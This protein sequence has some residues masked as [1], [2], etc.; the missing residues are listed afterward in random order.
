MHVIWARGQEPGNY[1][2]APPSGLEK[3]SASVKEFYKPDELKYHGHK[4]QRGF[5]QI[6]FFDEIKPAANNDSTDSPH[7]LDN[8]CEGFWKHP[9]TCEPS[10]FNCEYHVSWQTIGRGDEMRFQIQT[11]NTK[12]WT[13]IGFSED[14]KMSQTDAIIGWVDQNGRPFLMDT[15]INGFS[16]PKLDDQQNIYNISGR[17]Q[18]GATTLEFTRKRQTDDKSDLSF[19]DDHCLRLMFPVAGGRFNAVNKKMSKH[20]QTPIVTEARICIKS[21]GRDLIDNTIAPERKLPSQLAY[22]VSVKL[23]NLAESFE[24]PSK[25]TPEFDSLASQLSNSMAGVLS[26]IPGYYETNVNSFEK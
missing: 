5:T 25:G 19:T 6:N 18:N 17:T 22:A 23:M 13:G 12:T 11:T 14:E 21:C 26:H 20:E 24:S 10:K 8:D 3:E 1:V 7:L 9:R 4:S 2:H 15:W 16:P